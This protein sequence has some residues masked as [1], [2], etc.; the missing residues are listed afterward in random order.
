MREL[1]RAARQGLRLT[2]HYG[3]Q[4]HYLGIGKH[5]SVYNATPP[6]WLRVNGEIHR[7]SVGRVEHLDDWAHSRIMFFERKTATEYCLIDDAP[8]FYG[9]DPA[10]TTVDGEIVLTSVN[11]SAVGKDNYLLKTEIRRADDIMRLWECWRDIP[12]KDNRM[13]PIDNGTRIAVT[14]RP[15]SGEAGRGKMAYIELDTLDDLCADTLRGARIIEMPNAEDDTW[16]GPNELHNLYRKNQIGILLHGAFEDNVSTSELMNKTYFILFAWLDRKNLK[17]V[18]TEVLALREDFPASNGKK[19]ALCNV[20]F[21]TGL[22]FPS[23]P[24]REHAELYAGIGDSVQAFIL[25]HNP[26]IVGLY[27]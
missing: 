19:S 11:V 20:A 12:G 2:Q 27:D 3:Q 14:T 1:Y 16:I 8:V 7:V 13:T 24:S 4:V 15:Q 9:E 25:I 6:L 18:D 22:V 5:L 10:V 23:E 26:K 17:I 21:G